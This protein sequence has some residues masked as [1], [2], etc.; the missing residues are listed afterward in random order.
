MTVKRFGA[1]LLGAAVLL[2][3]PAGPV[4]AVTHPSSAA[5]L[6]TQCTG[7]DLHASKGQF[8]SAITS[9]SLD[10]RVTNT[11]DHTC[12]TAGF[13]LF[14]FRNATGLIGWTSDGNP[15]LDLAAPVVLSPGETTK[16]VLRWASPAY[17]KSTECHARHASGVRL[18][19]NDIDRSY[20][21][22][23]DLRVCTTKKH[24]PSATRLGAI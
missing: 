3:V 8:H 12:E 7:E 21:L 14:R 22:R 24:R 10:V 1:V 19:I 23:V 2:V 9:R 6:A 11:G 15:V 20:V 4:P 16:S 17:T 18:R 5:A 13:T